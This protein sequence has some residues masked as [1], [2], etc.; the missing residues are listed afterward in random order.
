LSL[1]SHELKTPITSLQLGLQVM[2][3]A[4]P[5]AG[6]DPAMA[7]KLARATHQVGRLANLSQ[8]LLDVVML[9]AGG[10]VLQLNDA[11]LREVIAQAVAR[12]AEEARRAK[13]PIVLSAGPPVRVRCDKAWVEQAVT[14]LITNAIKFGKGR[15]IDLAVESKGATARITVTDHGI[16]V[17]LED[18]RRIFERFERAVPSRHYG[19]LGLGLY[20]AR[21]VAHAHAGSILVASEPDEG[22]TFTILLPKRGTG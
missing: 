2:K 22:S 9:S 16:G 14:N 7:A 6:D 8:N 10:V 13:C 5:A 18:R 1:A 21:E 20:V 11:D 15:P 17:P 4:R 19:G 12:C 3:N